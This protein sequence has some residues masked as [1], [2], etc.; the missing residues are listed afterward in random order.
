MQIFGWAL[1]SVQ[2]VVALLWT[3]AALTQGKRDE[4]EAYWRGALSVSSCVL[5]VLTLLGRL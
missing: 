2:V 4:V 3:A 1:V 5:V